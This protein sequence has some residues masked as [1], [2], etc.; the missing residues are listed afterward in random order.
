[1]NTVFTT[2]YGIYTFNY[3]KNVFQPFAPLNDILDSTENTRKI[4]QHEGKTWFVQD[5]E[6]G[7]FEGNSSALETEYFL[8]FKGTFNRG[9]DCIIPLPNDQILLGTKTGLYLYD[10]TFRNNIEE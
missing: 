1:E 4:I 9:M 10:L 6:V 3:A 2:N 8:Q 5:D 7:F